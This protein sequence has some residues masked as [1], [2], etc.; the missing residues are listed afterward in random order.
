[1]AY[2][3]SVADEFLHALASHGTTT[4]LVFG[5]HFAGA[6]SIFMHKARA[7]GLRIVSGLTLADRGLRPD[8]HSTP[9]RAYRESPELIR[10]FHGLDRLRYAV[11]PRFALA[12]SEALL[13]VCQ[14]LLKENSGVAFQTHMNENRRE[15]ES[16]AR[17]FPNSRDYLGVYEEFGLATNRSVFAH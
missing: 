13:E 3:A 1:G 10:Q 9:E 17:L 5:A 16:V 8:L 2:A 4:A 6:T 12:T 14:T 15:V 11:T 7:S